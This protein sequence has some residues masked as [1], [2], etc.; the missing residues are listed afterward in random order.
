MCVLVLL[1]AIDPSGIK[2]NAVGSMPTDLCHRAV[3]YK[4]S[5]SMRGRWP[6]AAS[7]CDLVRY[8]K[9]SLRLE[10]RYPRGPVLLVPFWK[11]R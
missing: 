3:E 6:L 9:S 7:G 11:F 8:S 4:T 1:S 2:G 10:Q 5:D